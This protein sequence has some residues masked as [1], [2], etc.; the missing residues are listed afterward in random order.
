MRRIEF[1]MDPV[2]IDWNTAEV[3]P[4]DGNFKLTASFA[5]QAPPKW[6]RAFGWAIEVL[7]KETTGAQWESIRPI[8]EPPGGLEVLGAREESITALRAFLDSCV[9]MANEQAERD[10]AE[11]EQQ[12]RN[13]DSQK[14]QS[15]ETAQRLTEAL[16]S[17]ASTG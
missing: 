2:L 14:T 1:A 5:R 8:G 3:V 9:R 10:A 12:L 7:S 11:L 13:R 6:W 17:G 4:A 16:R 15:K